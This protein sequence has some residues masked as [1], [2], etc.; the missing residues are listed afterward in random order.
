[1]STRTTLAP[2]PTLDRTFL[3][4]VSTVQTITVPNECRMIKIASTAAI[5]LLKFGAT[6]PTT[7]DYDDFVLPG[8]S[9]YITFPANTRELRILPHNSV[10]TDIYIIEK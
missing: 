3:S 1:M 10:V 4:A 9:E 7:T 6:N 8:N 2:Q 5:L